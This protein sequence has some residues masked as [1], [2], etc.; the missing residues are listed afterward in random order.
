M[1]DGTGADDPAEL[2]RQEL[3]GAYVNFYRQLCKE[4]G[5]C[6][7]DWLLG[8]T[9]Q[10]V[11]REPQSTDA[12]T[13]FRFYHAVSDG[14][15]ALGADCKRY[16]L[17]F[18]KAAEL[19]ETLCVNLFLQPWKKEIRT[20]KTFTGPFVYCLLP[21]LNSST[22]KSV[23]ASIG[24]LPHGDTSSEFTLSEDANPDKAMQVGFELLLAR[25]ECY[26]F[27]ELLEKDQLGPQEWMEVLQRRA[28]QRKT[29]KPS[30]RKT[31]EPQEE[32]TTN[33]EE[34][35]VKDIQ[36]IP[37]YSCPDARPPQP[38]P[39]RGLVNTDP[40]LMEMQRTYPDLAFRGRPLVSDKPRPANTSWNSTKDAHT[41]DNKTAAVCSENYS[42]KAPDTRSGG[43]PDP[44]STA[45]SINGPS[46]PQVPSQVTPQTLGWEQ[47]QTAADNNLLKPEHSLL[48]SVDEEQDLRDLAHRM[49]Q[50]HEAG[51]EVKNPTTDKKTWKKEKNLRKP[52]TETTP[53]PSCDASRCTRPSQMDP[54]PLKEPKQPGRVHFSHG[55]ILSAGQ[56]GD[57][58]G[59][60]PGQG[61]ERMAHSFVFIK[62]Y[63]K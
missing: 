41:A 40:S 51:E 60:D 53:L 19:L 48:S 44:G 47:C 36:R 21:V 8:R 28:G 30:D 59:A 16:L 7:D 43:V 33:K 56:Q 10:Y 34:A 1:K 55:T 52:V 58:S 12:F 15:D 50:N 35:N 6:R 26:H 46:G 54:T 2:S 25:V 13:V 23:L 38:K 39:R 32:E 24:Y 29:R 62:S 3:C 5:P 17:A 18:I 45:S 9:A 37:L 42:N 63:K 14:L 4:V 20:V 31:A 11:V 61:E 57:G 27:L 49:G 22:I